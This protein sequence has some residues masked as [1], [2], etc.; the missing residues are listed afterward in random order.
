[1]KVDTKLGIHVI[2]AVEGMYLV[3]HPNTELHLV[4]D[5]EVCWANAVGRLQ[6]Q[7]G[8]IFFDIELP[9]RPLRGTSAIKLSK[10]KRERDYRT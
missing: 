1:M 5:Q 10:R 2:R 8:T 3:N 9:S 4:L 6:D 7:L